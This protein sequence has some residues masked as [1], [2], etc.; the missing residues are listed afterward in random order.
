MEIYAIKGHLVKVTEET[1]NYGHSS[2]VE[3]IKEKIQIGKTYT[4]DHTNVFG[5]RTEVFLEE[6]PGVAFN[7]V[8]FVDVT[9]Q[10][11]ELSKKHKDYSKYH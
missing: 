1:K 9:S 11:V 8:N 5:F 2:D 6:I 3:L 4:V 10:P 7:S